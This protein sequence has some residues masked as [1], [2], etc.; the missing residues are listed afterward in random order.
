VRGVQQVCTRSPCILL[1]NLTPIPGYPPPDDEVRD[2]LTADLSQAESY[3]RMCAFLEALFQHTGEIIQKFDD[4]ELENL[5]ATF[6]RKMTEGQ[7][8]TLV[9]NFRMNFYAAVIQKAKI[10]EGQVWNRFA[11]RHVI[12]NHV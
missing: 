8:Y 4:S 7:M 10:R 5:P 3:N 12:L 1:V 11:L 6:R 9:N 2:Y